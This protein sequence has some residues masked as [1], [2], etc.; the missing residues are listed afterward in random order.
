MRSSN[1]CV[2]GPENVSGSKPEFLDQKVSSCDIHL[3]K[4]LVV[5]YFLCLAAKAGLI[6][7]LARLRLPSLECLTVASAL[8]PH[9]MQTTERATT[10]IETPETALPTKMPTVSLFKDH[11]ND[12]TF[13]DIC[14]SPSWQPH[15]RPPPLPIFNRTSIT[16]QASTYP[17][18]FRSWRRI[19][20]TKS[21]DPSPTVRRRHQTSTSPNPTSMIQSFRAALFASATKPSTSTTSSCA[22]DLST[23]ESSSSV[24][25]R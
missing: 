13:S 11:F 16:P 3:H 14:W 17:H 25:S 6:K 1:R 8:Q 15:I 9:S 4:T 24:R 12:P 19:S 5:L 10:F 21:Q 22:V 20:S 2:L 23:S 18:H 7:P